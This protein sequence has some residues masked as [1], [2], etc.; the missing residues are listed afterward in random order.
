MVKSK[1]ADVQI[2]RCHKW[3]RVTYMVKVRNRVLEI[4]KT[5]KLQ[6]NYSITC[7]DIRRCAHP[8]FTHSQW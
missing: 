2:C 4:V 7:C 3:V 6:L 1:S 5:D 8:L